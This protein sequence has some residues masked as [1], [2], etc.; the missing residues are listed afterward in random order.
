MDDKLNGITVG[1]QYTMLHI[2]VMRGAVAILFQDIVP[3]SSQHLC[4]PGY[5]PT[6]ND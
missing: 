3:T 5:P 1:L 4:H 6:L 2:W